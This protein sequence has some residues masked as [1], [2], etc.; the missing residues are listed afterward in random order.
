MVF[1]QQLRP[2]GQ[3]AKGMIM[4]RIRKMSCLED[5]DDSH[6][7]P[8]KEAQHKIIE[9]FSEA[10][11]TKSCL[12]TLGRIAELTPY[13]INSLSDTDDPWKILTN[14][15]L[16]K[17]ELGLKHMQLDIAEVLSLIK[18]QKE[19]MVEFEAKFSKKRTETEVRRMERRK[20]YDA[21]FQYKR[22]IWEALR[23]KEG[24]CPAPNPHF[25]Y[26]VS[27][28]PENMQSFVSTVT[29]IKI[30]DYSGH[31]HIICP[32]KG[33]DNQTAATEFF[34]SIVENFGGRTLE[35]ELIKYS[36]NEFNMIAKNDPRNV[37]GQTDF[38]IGERAIFIG[39][40]GKKTQIEIKGY[41]KTAPFLIYGKYLKEKGNLYR[42]FDIRNLE[43]C[44]NI[45]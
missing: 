20:F 27:L 16:E 36:S 34:K 6:V 14:P 32:I 17:I 19:T 31:T 1:F 21:A 4:A 42:M 28:S 26:K 25:R 33:A 45:T 43:R 30:N 8:I 9:K 18:K 41:H 12:S 3:A 39:D 35:F 29:D 2:M 38:K 7:R 24:I 5:G 13:E 44:I 22:R 40:D 15:E 11:R 10:I 37:S 23:S